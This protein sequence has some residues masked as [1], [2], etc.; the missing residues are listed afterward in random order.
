MFACLGSIGRRR[1]P[2]EAVL[3]SLLLRL[4]WKPP[5][6]ALLIIGLPKPTDDYYS[7]IGLKRLGN[8]EVLPARQV[9]LKPRELLWLSLSNYARDIRLLT[10]TFFSRGNPP[11][12]RGLGTF[13]L[14]YTCYCIVCI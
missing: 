3:L 2:S 13:G 11:D 7:G 4:M 1:N 9:F 5:R 8:L 10:G 12:L 6:I 14:W